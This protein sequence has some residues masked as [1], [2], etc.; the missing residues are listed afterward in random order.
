[1]TDRATP[2]T[3]TVTEGIRRLVLDHG[4]ASYDLSSA[5]TASILYPT[6]PSGKAFYFE[7]RLGGATFRVT[8]EKLLP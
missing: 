2:R 5:P 7:T 8:V 3:D 4:Y 1:V 6:D